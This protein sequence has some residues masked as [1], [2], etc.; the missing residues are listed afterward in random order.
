MFRISSWGFSRFQPGP[1][2]VQAW[3]GVS[4]S[5]VEARTQESRI[6]SAWTTANRLILYGIWIFW[7]AEMGGSRLAGSWCPGALPC[8]WAWSFEVEWTGNDMGD[9]GAE[10][11]HEIEARIG[12]LLR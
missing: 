8:A 7:S 2:T 11:T 10:S 9:D 4:R 5:I 1:N 6:A 3:F 12:I